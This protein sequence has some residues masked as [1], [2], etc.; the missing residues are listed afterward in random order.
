MLGS[1]T[2]HV[3]RLGTSFRGQTRV[4]QRRLGC[5]RPGPSEVRSAR[6]FAAPVIAAVVGV[7][8][9]FLSPKSTTAESHEQTDA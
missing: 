2:Y 9:N 7:G 4:S 6:L 1:K 8:L 3:K 5:L